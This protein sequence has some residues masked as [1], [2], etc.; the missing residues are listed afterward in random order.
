MVA[1]HTPLLEIPGFAGGGMD[2]GG[3]GCSSS[4]RSC[5]SLQ[6]CDRVQ[7]TR[8]TCQNTRNFKIPS[9]TY[10]EQIRDH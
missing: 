10:C 7:K 3:T 2:E 5:R 6:Y 9:E 1:C 4:F 8:F